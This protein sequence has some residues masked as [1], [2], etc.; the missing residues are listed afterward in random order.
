MN[1]GSG[2]GRQLAMRQEIYFRGRR[3]HSPEYPGLYPDI[4]AGLL[5]PIMR[6]PP[7]AAY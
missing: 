6:N 5:R 4:Q 3:E 1:D 7:L 2:G